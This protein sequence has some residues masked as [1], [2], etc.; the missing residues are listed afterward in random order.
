MSNNDNQMGRSL[1]G[2]AAYMAAMGATSGTDPY[3][4]HQKLSGNGPRDLRDEEGTALTEV[5]Y[6]AQRLVD[7]ID[8]INN[9]GV[10]RQ[11]TRENGCTA[12]AQI[13]KL[14]EEVEELNNAIIASDEVEIVDGIGD[15]ITVLIQIARLTQVSLEEATDR[16]WSQIRYRKGKMINGI[17]V[18]DGDV[19]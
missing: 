17:F 19:A 2:A 13:K 11:L 12:L 6:D 1:T 3:H 14:R 18:K 15:A 9:W 16:A 7:N 5:N 8:K 10:E 4:P